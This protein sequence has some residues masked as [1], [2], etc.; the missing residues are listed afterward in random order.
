MKINLNKLKEFVLARK[1]PDGGFA[2][3]KPLQS[4]LPETFYAIFILKTIGE[5][6]P[7]E[8]KIVKFLKRS[9]R[10]DAYS[11]YWTYKSL[12]LLEKELPDRSDFI[13]EKLKEA[14]KAKR[15]GEIRAGGITAT[16]SFAMPNVL[17][18]VFML[19]EALRLLGM[20]VPKFVSS[21]VKNFEKNGGFGLKRPNLEETYYCLSVLGFGNKRNLEFILKHENSEGFVKFPQSYPP[22]VEDTFYALSCLKILG[23][24]YKNRKIVDWIAILQ[25]ADGGFRR[26]TYGGISTLENSFYAVASLKLLEEL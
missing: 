17:R 9:I 1:N 2:F 12:S 26:S 18:E 4:T 22:Y 3:C 7:E 24:K 6:I 25:N 13:L 11:I 21:F 5:R 10:D 15:S 20:E 16:Y 8:G 14:I 19:S 23:Y